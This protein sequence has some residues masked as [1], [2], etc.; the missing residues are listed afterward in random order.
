MFSFIVLVFLFLFP[1]LITSQHDAITLCPYVPADVR[2]F[3]YN[4]FCLNPTAYNYDTRSTFTIP[5]FIVSSEFAVTNTYKPLNMRVLHTLPP[6]TVATLEILDFYSPC[7]YYNDV[8]TSCDID[9]CQFQ[10]YITIPVKKGVLCVVY[11]Q[12]IQSVPVFDN[13]GYFSVVLPTRMFTLTAHPNDIFNDFRPFLNS[14]PDTVKSRFATFKFT[15]KV[16]LYHKYF[17]NLLYYIVSKEALNVK[18]SSDNSVHFNINFVTNSS[19]FFTTTGLIGT[20]CAAAFTHICTVRQQPLPTFSVEFFLLSSTLHKPEPNPFL[21]HIVNLINATSALPQILPEILAVV[22]NANHL[23]M[24]SQITLQNLAS[25][26]SRNILRDNAKIAADPKQYD[27]LIKTF[28]DHTARMDSDLKAFTAVLR[29]LG[30]NTTFLLT[31]LR[32]ISLTF[33][34]LVAQTNLNSSVFNVQVKD[35][36]DLIEIFNSS[37]SNINVT[38]NQKP[39]L[40]LIEK[41]WRS[42]FYILTKDSA[43]L[44]EDVNNV[45]SI[46]GWLGNILISVFRPFFDLL[47]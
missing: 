29:S 12:V 42:Y 17:D 33:K 38:L 44:E 11:K 25:S 6:V 34:K 46:F 39:T 26:F 2:S 10:A 24:Q 15:N 4:R 41:F 40:Q 31:N 28:R 45:G 27:A 5:T 9:H 3:Y 23:K 37:T 47:I 18:C 36:S 19:C 1:V 43:F 16:F 22:K 30:T 20:I 32:E 21:P 14:L 35:F 7:N 13:N 8:N